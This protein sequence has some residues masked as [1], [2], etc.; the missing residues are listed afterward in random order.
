M[1]IKR[2]NSRSVN[3]C[4]PVTLPVWAC[5]LILSVTAGRDV[6]G[7]TQTLDSVVASVGNVA[8]TASDVMTEYRFERF[9]D[10]QWPPPPPD[11]A[12]LG[13]V[14][15]RLTYQLLLTQEEDITAEDR[16]ESEAAARVRLA[17]VQKEFPHSED[18]T[19]ALKD[20]GMTQAEV[21]AR[22]AQ[23]D[24]M[25]RLVN[26]RLRPEASPSD[27]DI[28]NYYRSSFVPEF[29]RKNP[30]GLAPPP[31]AEVADQIREILVQKRMNELLDQW[32][33]ELRPASEVRYHSD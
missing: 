23:Q 3:G 15:Q 7:A 6:R 5:V 10:G 8:I 12:T 11:A 17:E 31:L 4:R 9:L 24:L 19:G 26:Q 13:A 1:T 27:D 21:Q 29:L 2:A 16:A 30:A 32:I 25:L 18:F 28:A 20:L 22:I 14:R 33:N